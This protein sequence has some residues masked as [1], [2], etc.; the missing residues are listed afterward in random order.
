MPVA[1]SQPARSA[2]MGSASL[3]R[4]CSPSSRKGARS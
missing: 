1:G 4:T 2:S 3:T